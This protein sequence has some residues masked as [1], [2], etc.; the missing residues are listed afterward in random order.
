MNKDGATGLWPV[1]FAI[2][3]TIWLNP[4]LS[5]FNYDRAISLTQTTLTGTKSI[6]P[7]F[8]LDGGLLCTNFAT[9]G[10]TQNPSPF[11]FPFWPQIT[12]PRIY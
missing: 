2:L 4:Q 9:Q 10:S 12:P 7:Y 8:T 3:T 5:Q 1:I 6:V 11:G